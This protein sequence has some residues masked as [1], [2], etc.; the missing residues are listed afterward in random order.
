MEKYPTPFR[1]KKSPDF[2]SI[3]AS[4]SDQNKTRSIFMSDGNSLLLSEQNEIYIYAL[5]DQ[6]T[7]I[8][9]KRAFLEVG[10]CYSKL[11]LAFD[12]LGKSLLCRVAGHITPSF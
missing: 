7:P 10:N 8:R 3:G 5:R 11:Q 9:T 6:P 1:T 2:V 4:Y 12:K